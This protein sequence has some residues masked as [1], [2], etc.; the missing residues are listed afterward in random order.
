MSIDGV[1]GAAAS[2]RRRCGVLL[3]GVLLPLPLLAGCT[4]GSDGSGG[5]VQQDV[6]SADR[7]AVRDGGTL[8]WAID[9]MPGTFN[10]FQADADAAS[11]RIAGAVLPTLLTL[12]EKG[13]PQRNPDYLEAAD[14]VRTEPKQVVVY[15]LNP[16]AKWTDG[17]AV[18]ALD[19]AAQWKALSGKDSAYW[20]ARNAGYDRIQSVR[21]GDDPHQVEVTFR[22]PYGDWQSLF[23][24]LYPR[25]VMGSPG[26]FNDGARRNLKATAGP[27]RLKGRDTD[28]NTVTVERNPRWWGDR[29]KLDR[30][31]FKAVPRDRRTA[32]LEA[33]SLDLATVDRS[34]AKKI[35]G[36]GG[37]QQAKG[38]GEQGNAGAPA[39]EPGSSAAEASAALKSWARAHGTAE[40][41]A[42]E[43]EARAAAAA[44]VARKKALEGYTLR[45]SLE[46]AYT[47]L[48]MN[49]ESGPLSDERVR[50]AVARAL[51]RQKLAEAVLKPLGLPAEPLGNHLRVAGQ[52]GYEDNSSALGSQDTEAAQGLLT[53]AG[54]Q[55]VPGSRPKPEQNAAEEGSKPE[56]G[57]KARN[58]VVVAKKNGKALTL[59]FVLPT[60][61]GTESV[62]MVGSRI[63]TMLDAIGIRTEIVK[64][65]DDSY[66]K[67]YVASGGYDL[68][69]YSWPATAFPA[70]DG[71][72][73]F[74]KPRPGND[75]SLIV[76]QNYTRV[77]TD[78][79][80]Q[81][82]EQALAELD[83]DESREL[84]ARADA[85]I[86]AVA[87]S[88]PLF[89]RP[90]LV[91][92]K[93]K[94]ANAGA[95]GF[96][97]PRYQDIGFRR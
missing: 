97:T 30:I 73:I 47:Q 39:A 32:A 66:F 54:W 79:I 69:L 82:F 56:D 95:F 68:A 25:S 80:D 61:P 50:R 52:Q 72:P 16:K 12:D 29:A 37:V 70:T 76:E 88:I 10:T 51:D 46:P 35:Q 60:G 34:T 85:R 44:A 45:K 89:Q 2:G 11:D 1:R 23:T 62:R 78:R 48:A 7:G 58:D 42:D 20:T 28:R 93:A 43:K 83:P 31:V 65:A 19:F 14:V 5:G 15:K 4:S 92:V 26:A 71:R 38:K 27:F 64:V 94:V 87:G 57:E 81:L 91:A 33:G 36:P 22:K 74:A 55:P 6:A 53:E 3:A 18:R 86:W 13:R 9:T 8:R 40:E 90:Q 59:R 77:G 24:P 17:R 67:D 84:M 41:R 96:S 63:S 21:Q 49:G 75:G